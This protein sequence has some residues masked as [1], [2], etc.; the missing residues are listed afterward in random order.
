MNET[1]WTPSPPLSLVD[2]SVSLWRSLRNGRF[3]FNFDTISMRRYS[4]MDQYV[5]PE[6]VRKPTNRLRPSDEGK[7]EELL[8]LEEEQRKAQVGIDCYILLPFLSTIR[9]IFS[10]LL[11]FTTR[12]A[13]S[14]SLCLIG[15]LPAAPH[16]VCLASDIVSFVGKRKIVTSKCSRS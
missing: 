3:H 15:A 8:Q 16:C 4:I 7:S 10:S 1:S 2:V 13:R 6:K 12:L 14:V 11:N 5:F 9:P